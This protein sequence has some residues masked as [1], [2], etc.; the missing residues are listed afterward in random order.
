MAKLVN[1]A[2]IRDDANLLFEI[3]HENLIAR[4]ILYHKS[5][6]KSTLVQLHELQVILKKSLANEPE[7]IICRLCSTIT[8]FPV[9]E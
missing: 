4:E 5:C 3:K 2:Q 1:A 9:K 8:C 7:P 6:Y